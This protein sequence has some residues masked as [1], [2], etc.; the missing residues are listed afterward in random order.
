MPAPASGAPVR[1]A[2]PE[3]VLEPEPPEP[4]DEPEPVAPALLVALMK[5]QTMIGVN[6]RYIAYF[7]RAPLIEEEAEARAPEAELEALERAE[8]AEEAAFQNC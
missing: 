2:K 3:D 4:P 8:A 5:C 1:A 7:E 6:D